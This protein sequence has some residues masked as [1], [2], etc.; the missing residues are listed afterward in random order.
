MSRIIDMDTDRYR[1]Q[2]VGR[3]RLKERLNVSRLVQRRIE[4]TV[5]T[6]WVENDRHAVMQRPH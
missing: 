5:E 4:P 6:A 1:F 3:A 2:P